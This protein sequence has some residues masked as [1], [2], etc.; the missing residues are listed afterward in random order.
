MLGTR[1]AQHLIDALRAYE[2]VSGYVWCDE[3]GGI[4][5]DTDDP[6]NFGRPDC[7]ESDHMPV[8]VRKGE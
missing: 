5:E 2:A 4:H 7:A 1:D 3:H 6:Y 8:Y